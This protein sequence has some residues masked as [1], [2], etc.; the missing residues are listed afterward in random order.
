MKEAENWSYSLNQS[1]DW[2]IDWLI[3]GFFRNVSEEGNKSREQSEAIRSGQN[4]LKSVK[5]N[6]PQN[7]NIYKLSETG[8][9]VG[10]THTQ[11]QTASNSTKC[12]EKNKNNQ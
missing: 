8:K 7:K 9:T 5:H 10:N 2:L 3:G 1:K 12:A 6:G 11:L 4:E